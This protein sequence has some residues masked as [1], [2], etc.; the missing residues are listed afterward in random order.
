MFQLILRN[1]SEQVLAKLVPDPFD[2]ERIRRHLAGFKVRSPEAGTPA[3]HEPYGGGTRPEAGSG[4]TPR[5]S[6]R[7]G[8]W[9]GAVVVLA[10]ALAAAPTRA[11]YSPFRPGRV[12]VYGGDGRE[13][14]RYDTV[15]KGVPE[16][17]FKR[18]LRLEVKSVSISGDPTYRIEERDSL[19]DRHTVVRLSSTLPPSSIVDLPD[20]VVV[21]QLVYVQ[22]QGGLHLEHGDS[23][24]L[25]HSAGADP[26]FPTPSAA[27]Q[28]SPWQG[29]R[30]PYKGVT[31]LSNYV[32]PDPEPYQPGYKLSIS[33]S[34]WYVDD[35]GM[36]AIHMAGFRSDCGPEYSGNVW[37]ESLDGK[38]LDL[39]Q[40][41]PG[42][43]VAKAAGEAKVACGLRRPAP[44]R[45]S[46][47]RAGASLDLLGRALSAREPRR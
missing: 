3:S 19:F 46:I 5:G 47:V 4:P 37:L 1:F 21:R 22:R 23:L 16:Y 10:A 35:V 20:T 18:R 17:Q 38:E 13:Q 43:P 24:G 41:V 2:R 44:G 45:I 29:L 42:R 26:F 12:W 14:Q 40:P 27:P 15:R 7:A 39:G 34:G 28:G 6:S 8:G 11:D 9:G 30:A 25:Y 36:I 33:I 31:T 32:L